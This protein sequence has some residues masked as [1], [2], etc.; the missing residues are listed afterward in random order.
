MLRDG[1]TLA[2]VLLA[3]VPAVCSIRRA[4]PAVP[5]G[6]SVLSR[7][8]FFGPLWWLINV[9]PLTVTYATSRHLYLPA[10]GLAVVVGI[11][12]DVLRQ[13][14]RPSV[15]AVPVVAAALVGLCVARLQGPIGEWVGSAGISEKM[16]GDL[17]AVASSAPRGTLIVLGAPRTASLSPPQ[18]SPR[19]LHDISP[20]PGQPWLW[21]WATPY[22]HQ[23]PFMSAEL[24]ER[25]GYV[26]PLL[27]DCCG[28]EQWFDRSLPEIKRW[29]EQPE[30]AP[31]IVVAWQPDTGTLVRASD[32]ETPC[33]R[34]RALLLIQAWSPEL[35]DR[36]I[37]NLVRNVAGNQPCGR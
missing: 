30:P 26:G 34:D 14:R 16:A 2:I 35:L 36:G 6:D 20:T 1:L 32:S 4:S 25:V 33:L 31:V 7:L 15:F 27:I 22:I 24:S 3:V 28:A 18:L 8:V 10:A 11:L 13:V 5:P 17:H 21:S 19:V 23:P 29:A 12:F 9:A 37:G